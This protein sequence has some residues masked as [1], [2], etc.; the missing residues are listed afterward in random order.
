MSGIAYR[1]LG[2]SGLIVSSLALGT[3]TFGAPGWGTS[4]EAAAHMLDAY[5]ESGGNF[6]D[7]A[8]VYAGGRSESLVGRYI[9]ER[10]LRDRLVLATKFTFQG[11]VPAYAN[12]GGNGRKNMY[13]ALEGSLRRL[14]TDYIDL[15]WMHAWDHV[16]PV[17]EVLQSLGDLVHAGKIRY[18]GFSDIPA[19]YATKA[20]TLASVH[21]I[22]GP[23][24]LQPEYSLI[25]RSIER[26][27]LPASR[28][29][30]LGVCAWSPLAGGFLTGKYR[31]DGKE[32]IGEGRLDTGKGGNNRA[33]AITER[34]WH[35][36]SA[37]RTIA[38]Q[39]GRTP[40]QVALAWASAQP[41]ITSLILGASKLEQLNDNLA[42]TD[43][44][45]TAD[46]LRILNDISALEP[47]HPYMI[48]PDVVSRAI[49]GGASVQGW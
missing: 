43:F 42:S 49:F 21:A 19:W 45:L 20:A 12:A 28:E 41:G 35:T 37:V 48:T 39:V 24:A 4:D 29:C 16:T 15:Y 10:G 36:L 34:H 17:E 40:A 8:D 11:G 22:P 3:M 38:E 27:H 44:R 31:P 30:S 33:Q 7:T 46:Q 14:R 13:R 26:E 5:I 2:R 32:V 9:A 1:T 18:F 25:E 6:I 23:I 47:V